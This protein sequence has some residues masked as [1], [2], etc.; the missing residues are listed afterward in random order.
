MQLSDLER[1]EFKIKEI[2]ARLDRIDKW[3]NRVEARMENQIDRLD[4]RVNNIL[5]V[6]PPY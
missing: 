2:E 5:K 4:E 1:P 6:S 3:T